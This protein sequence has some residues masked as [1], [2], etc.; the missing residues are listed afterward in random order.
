MLTGFWTLR[1]C[2]SLFYKLIKDDPPQL[3]GKSPKTIEKISMK[4]LR[5]W[6]EINHPSSDLVVSRELLERHS[7]HMTASNFRCLRRLEAEGIKDGLRNMYIN[8][9]VINLKDV[10]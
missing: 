5:Q 3:K 1:S 10:Y 8:D 4:Q 6:E 2:R 9:E 7:I